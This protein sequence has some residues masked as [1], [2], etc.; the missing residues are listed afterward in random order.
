M[1]GGVWQDPTEPLPPTLHVAPFSCNIR[2]VGTVE[3]ADVTI[4]LHEYGSEHA[5]QMK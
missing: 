1:N 4:R 2:I 3:Y 5:E